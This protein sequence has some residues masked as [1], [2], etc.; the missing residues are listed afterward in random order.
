MNTL[1]RDKKIQ[2]LRCLTEG[3]AVRATARVVG[4]SKGAVLRLIKAVGPAC[5]WFHHRYVH[6]VPCKRLELD[7]LHQFVYAKQKCLPE[8]LR[9]VPGFGTVWTWLGITESRL[10]LSYIVGGRDLGTC[11]DFI[12]DVA[13]R[14]RGKV[15]I[16]SD[17][18]GTYP[19]AIVEHFR[20]PMVDYATVDKDFEGGDPK[21]PEARYAPGKIRR[22]VKKVIIGDPDPAY[23]TTSHCERLNLTVRMQNKRY[24]RLTNAH[25]KRIT[26]HRWALAIQ[27]VFYNW[28]RVNSAVRGT[29][30]Q[31]TGLTDYR[32]TLADLLKLEMWGG[33]EML[34]VA[35]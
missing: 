20:Q 17:A 26:Y 27:V 8:H 35:N 1:H 11:K 21:R 14:V 31:A 2:I 25:S 15:Q 22:C 33:E 3:M 18:W 9:D 12:G 23:M 32:F 13:Y 7:E 19:T 6:D 4:V 29:P 10:I 16:T 28:C 24:A 34:Q 5:E 30:A